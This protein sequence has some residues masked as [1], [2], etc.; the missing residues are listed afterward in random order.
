LI[1][2]RDFYYEEIDEAT[3]GNDFDLVFNLQECYDIDGGKDIKKLS[4]NNVYYRRVY[5]Q[6][7]KSAFSAKIIVPIGIQEIT[8]EPYPVVASPMSIRNLSDK[9]FLSII[10]KQDMS[11]QN[12]RLERYAKE[13]R[14]IVHIGIS[15]TRLDHDS[16]GGDHES[17][18]GPASLQSLYDPKYNKFSVLKEANGRRD[19]F[20]V[21]ANQRRHF[22][23]EILR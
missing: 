22:I 2:V 14:D 11:Y 7:S 3:A 15:S 4:Y 9:N 18:I 6:A 23:K 20:Q 19:V 17:V 1:V 21:T 12:T 5:T 10:S 16:W 8:N 13:L